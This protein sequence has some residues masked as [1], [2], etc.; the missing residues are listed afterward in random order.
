MRLTLTYQGPLPASRQRVTN[1]KHDIRRQLHP[2]IKTQVLPR[3]GPNAMQHVTSTV[4]GFE[5]IT[6]VSARFRTAVEL[7]ILLLSR[8][9]TTPLGDMDNRLKNLIDGLTRPQ[10]TQQAQGF[11]PVEAGPTFCLMEDDVLVQRVGLDSRIWHAPDAQYQD[12]LVIVT[13][14]IVIGPNADMSSP[15]GNMFLVL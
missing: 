13:A 3:L 5:F 15:T 1:V 4:G 10:S 11:S 14:T 2:Q 6:P 12:A 7:D 8:R 9:G